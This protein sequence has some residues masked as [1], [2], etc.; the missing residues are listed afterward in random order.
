M[1]LENVKVAS[2]NDKGEVVTTLVAWKKAL[3]AQL[4]G[5]QQPDGTWINGKNDRWME[6]MPLLCTC[7]ALAALERCQ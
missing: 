1:Q 7:Y 4:E 2:K 6:N 3:R 5:M